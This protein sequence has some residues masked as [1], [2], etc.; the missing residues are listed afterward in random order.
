MIVDPFSHTRDSFF[1][2]ILVPLSIL[3]RT[4]S[5]HKVASQSGNN[6]SSVHSFVSLSSLDFE[7]L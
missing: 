6:R 3:G 1:E 4:C 5:Y 7:G 2:S